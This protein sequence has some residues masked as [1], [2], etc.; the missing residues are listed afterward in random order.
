MKKD[1]KMKRLSR[2]TWENWFI[3]YDFDRQDGT[4]SKCGTQEDLIDLSILKYNNCF[5]LSRDQLRDYFTKN[6]K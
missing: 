5:G 1:S 3:A 2:F 4:E 6:D